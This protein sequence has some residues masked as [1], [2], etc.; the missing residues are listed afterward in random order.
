MT[1]IRT[2]A[3]YLDIVKRLKKEKR[4]YSIEVGKWV[5]NKMPTLFDRVTFPEIYDE[6]E[7]YKHEMIQIH[8]LRTHGYTNKDIR[9]MGYNV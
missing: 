3:N 2:R 4:P 9:R 6:L 5:I 1:I 8:R 7:E